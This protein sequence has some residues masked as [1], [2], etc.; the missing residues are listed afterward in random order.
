MYTT[1]CLLVIQTYAKIWYACVKEQ[2]GYRSRPYR[3]NECT[4]RFVPWWYTHEPNKVWLC[5][6]TT[7]TEAWTQGHVINPINLTLRSKL[8][9]VSGSWMYLTHPLMVI[10][11]CPKYGM[12]MSKLTEVTGRTW[13]HVKNSIN[14]TLRSKFNVV[15][16]S[17][18]HATH[19]TLV[20]YP[21][22]K[23]GKPMSNQK[24]LWATDRRAYRLTDRRTDSDSYIPP[25]LRSRGL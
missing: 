3:V 15:S 25:E 18:M 4:R 23:Y 2:R 22:A 20:I 13:R 10:H 17:W 19:H 14:L 24:T 5:Q 6:R 9:V 12:S 21:C 11:P 7:K 16:G 8:K 1:R